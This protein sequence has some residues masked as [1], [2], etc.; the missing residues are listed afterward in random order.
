MHEVARAKLLASYTRERKSQ[1]VSK[2]VHKM[3]ESRNPQIAKKKSKD[4]RR[5]GAKAQVDHALG[6]CG[7]D[8]QVDRAGCDGAYAGS[9][10]ENASIALAFASQADISRPITTVLFSTSVPSPSVPSI[11]GPTRTTRGLRLM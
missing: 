9:S 3:Q 11:L 4:L 1:D 8:V 10:A 5:C 6:R 7:A 2:I